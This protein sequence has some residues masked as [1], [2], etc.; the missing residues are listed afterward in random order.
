MDLLLLNTVF[1][2]ASALNAVLGN[3][4]C[5]RPAGLP[6]GTGYE[7]WVFEESRRRLCMIFQT[8]G[9]LYSLEPAYACLVYDGYVLS[10]LPGRKGLWE[11]EMPELWEVEKRRGG[12]ASVYGLMVGGMMVKVDE[13]K[14]VVGTDGQ[15]DVWKESSTNWQEWCAGMDGLGGLVMLVASLPI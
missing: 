11:A 13:Y 3:N 9:M 4:P 12:E 2:I 14:S 5:F 7:D 1:I 8:I 6:Y 15:G 10:P